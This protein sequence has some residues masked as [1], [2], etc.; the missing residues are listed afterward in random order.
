MT[1]L[2]CEQ[3]PLQILEIWL[4]LLRKRNISYLVVQLKSS[5]QKVHHVRLIIPQCLHSM[6]Y[7]NSPLML[8][9]FTNNTDCTKR[10]TAAT[11]VPTIK[12]IKWLSY[13]WLHI[14]SS[15]NTRNGY[16]SMS[17]TREKPLNINAPKGGWTLSRALFLIGING[18]NDLQPIIQNPGGWKPEGN[19]MDEFCVTLFSELLKQHKKTAKI[20]TRYF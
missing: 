2:L 10:P 8:K 13:N 20:R 14:A 17:S 7:V 19:W 6:E 1:C 18:L 16:R 9:H 15:Y 3:L 5:Y 12:V 4:S 11:S